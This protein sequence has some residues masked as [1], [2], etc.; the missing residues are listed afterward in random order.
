MTNYCDSSTFFFLMNTQCLIQFCFKIH[1]FVLQLLH[2]SAVSP[3][4]EPV[5]FSTLLAFQHLHR[6]SDGEWIPAHTIIT[7]CITPNLHRMWLHSDIGAGGIPFQS[8]CPLQLRRSAG[9][10]I[11]AGQDK[12]G[13]SNFSTKQV[14][15]DLK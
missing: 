5:V 8:M 11:Y 13:T 12:T 14:P 10:W 2:W 9:L 4:A 3:E 15:R 1:F 7:C 6:W